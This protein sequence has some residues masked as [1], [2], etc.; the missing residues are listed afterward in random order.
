M[1]YSFLASLINDKFLKHLVTYLVPVFV[2]GGTV[3]SA[4]EVLEQ[5]SKDYKMLFTYEQLWRS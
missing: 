4:T 1:F 5:S 3:F 2:K